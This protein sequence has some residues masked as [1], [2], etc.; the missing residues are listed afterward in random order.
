MQ[1]MW[2]WVWKEGWCGCAW[3]AGGRG[4][5]GTMSREG[6]GVWGGEWRDGGRGRGTGNAPDWV[7][8]IFGRS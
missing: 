8:A 4:E 3:V 7:V 1:G 5:A 6:V 2:G